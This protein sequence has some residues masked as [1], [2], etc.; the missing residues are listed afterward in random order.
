M[1]SDQLSRFCHG[2]EH[3]IDLSVAHRRDNILHALF[4]VVNKLVVL[5]ID[6]VAPE[7]LESNNSRI[8]KRLQ[9][10]IIELS[11][12]QSPYAKI[13]IRFR[14]NR[15]DQ[16]VQIFHI[17][18][19]RIAVWHFQNRGDASHSS[20]TGGMRKVFF[21]PCAFRS[22]T[23]MAMRINESRKNKSSRRIDRLFRIA[24]Q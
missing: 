4:I 19:C 9:G 20:G 3:L 15:F 14:R 18:N 10:I 8:R 7:E 2:A 17:V 16:I 24:G 5:R 13:H 6:R 1:D 22:V 21:I 11:K 23:R 12:A